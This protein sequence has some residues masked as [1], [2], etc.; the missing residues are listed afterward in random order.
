VEGEESRFAF[1]RFRQI[2]KGRNVPDG[3]IMGD[4]EG[5]RRLKL[6]GDAWLAGSERR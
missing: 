1:M 2:K 3:M 5:E 6:E 4:S